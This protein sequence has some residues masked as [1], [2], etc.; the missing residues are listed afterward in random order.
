MAHS[1]ARFFLATALIFGSVAGVHAQGTADSITN[2]DIPTG[3]NGTMGGTAATG[4]TGVRTGRGPLS[5]SV[6]PAVSTINPQQNPQRPLNT[7]GP[8]LT[9]PPQQPFG[10]R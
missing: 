2:R 5:E 8:A 6:P 1:K 10:S 4:N 3:Q 9:N 7:W